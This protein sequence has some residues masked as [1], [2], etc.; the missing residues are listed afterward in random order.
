M[1]RKFAIE[2]RL[3]DRD[4]RAFCT[5]MRSRRTTIDTARAWLVARGHSI[6]RGAVWKFSQALRER[7]L[8]LDALTADGRKACKRRIFRCC[9]RLRGRDLALAAMLLEGMLN[10]DGRNRTSSNKS[11]AKRN[12]R[13]A[14]RG[15]KW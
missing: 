10:L 6:S 8:G 1:S 12:L 14:K 5:V 15:G 2:A 4:F 9:D 3:S 11:G 13:S 7:K